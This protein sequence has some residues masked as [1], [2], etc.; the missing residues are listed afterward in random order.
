MIL[1]RVRGLAQFA[2]S[3]AVHG[4]SIVPGRDPIAPKPLHVLEADAEFDLAVAEHVRVWSA[5]RAVFAQKM[6]EYAFP[7]LLRKAYAVQGDVEVS[8]NTPC[9][10]KI[11]RGR[12]IGVVVVL[13]IGHEQALDRVTRVL[14]QERSDGRVDA[15]RDADDH[16]G[17]GHARIIRRR[18]PDDRF[19]S[20]FAAFA[21]LACWYSRLRRRS[22]GT[23][24]RPRN[25]SCPKYRPI[26]RSGVG[27]RE[28]CRRQ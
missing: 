20:A 17:S 13:P 7:V 11:A 4:A 26:G 6:R 21:I 1:G 15:A 8:A 16:E 12:A 28:P 24:A 3:A 22:S 19:T 18:L 10:L 2:C 25:R 23:G 27:T 5:S 14:E 9:I